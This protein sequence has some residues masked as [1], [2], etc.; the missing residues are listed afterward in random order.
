MNTGDNNNYKEQQSTR[1]VELQPRNMMQPQHKNNI[2][3]RLES[4]SLDL[5]E[6]LESESIE[7]T[8]STIKSTRGFFLNLQALE[9]SKTG[10]TL[11]GEKTKLSI[12][13]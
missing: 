5:Q 7:L 3:Q 6:G 10:R 4:T 12:E 11:K 9:H 1:D 2:A 13:G 8:S